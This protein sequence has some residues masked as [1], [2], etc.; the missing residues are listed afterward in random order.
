MKTRTPFLLNTVFLAGLLLLAFNDHL[1]KD[2]YGNWWTGK[3]SDFAG[4]LI[5]PLFLKYVTGWRNIVV[6]GLTVV[7]FTWFKSPW[8]A[9]ALDAVN[10]LGIVHLVRVVDLT[11]LLAFAVLP[12]TWSVL[13]NPD[14]FGFGDITVQRRALVRYGVLPLCLFLFVATSDDEDFPFFDGS[15]ASCCEQLPTNRMIGNGYLYVPSAFTPDFDGINDVFQVVADSNIAMIDSFR[16]FTASN[17]TLVFSADSLTDFNP[18]TGWDGTDTTGNIIPGSFEYTLGVTAADG[19]QSFIF[20]VVCS[21]PCPTT[22]ATQPAEFFSDCT[23]GNQI[24]SLGRYDPSVNAFEDQD[25][26]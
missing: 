20:G 8:S 12:L 7:F 11:D 2:A 1:F 17:L 26:Y 19:T 6:V 22:E 25:C 21:L 18:A 4:V 13:V 24:D 3:L 5:L 15:V 10:A 9:G 23:F 14:R 16:V